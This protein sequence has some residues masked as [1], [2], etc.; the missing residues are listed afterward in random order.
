MRLVQNS[1]SVPNR[2]SDTGPSDASIHAVPIECPEH[3]RAE[4][5]IEFANLIKFYEVAV[6]GILLNHT[7]YLTR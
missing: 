4:G 6:E 2:I 3:Y 1:I 7:D 5:L